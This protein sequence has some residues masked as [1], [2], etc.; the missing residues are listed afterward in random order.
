MSAQ[1]S[2]QTIFIKVESSLANYLRGDIS[3]PEAKAANATVVLQHLGLLAPVMEDYNTNR[4]AWRDCP[5]AIV[6][7]EFFLWFRITG[8]A[9]DGSRPTLID[10][11]NALPGVVRTALP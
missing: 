4:L 9:E 6:K 5:Q 10:R 11:L 7:E 1:M 2:V 3:L 8:R